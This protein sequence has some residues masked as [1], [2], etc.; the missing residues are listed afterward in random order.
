MTRDDTSPEFRF[1]E[2]D[3]DKVRALFEEAIR[4]DVS[5]HADFLRSSCPDDPQTLE[6]VQELLRL[7]AETVQTV[8]NDTDKP[9]SVMHEALVRSDRVGPFKILDMIGEGGFGEVYLAEQ[10]E[11]VKRLVALKVIKLG[12]DTRSVIARFEAERQALALMDDPGIARVYDAGATDE[13][14]PYF[15]MEYVKGLSITTYCDREKLDIKHRLELFVRVCNAVQHAHQKGVIHRDIKPSNILVTTDHQDQAQPKVIDFGIAKATTQQLTE[16][17]LHTQQGMIIGTPE[18]MSPEQSVMHGSDV[19][20]RSDVYSLG[21][22]LYELLTGILP[23]DS[24]MLRKKDQSGVIGIIR[25]GDIPKPSSRLGSLTTSVARKIAHVRA[26]SVSDLNSMLRRELEWIPLMAMRKDRAE[27]Y[28]SV[29]DMGNDIKRYLE[30]HPLQAGPE[31]TTYRLKKLI[32]RHRGP[33]VAAACI[34]VVLFAGL[35]ATSYFALRAM[36]GEKLAADSQQLAQ[37]QADRATSQAKEAVLQSERALTNQARAEQLRIEADQARDEVLSQV[38]VGNIHSASLAKMNMDART[39]AR[40]LEQ[41]RSSRG[42]PPREELPFEWRYL[43]SSANGAA[44]TLPLPPD[45]IASHVIY[46]PDGSRIAVPGYKAIRIQDSSTGDIID[47]LPQPSGAFGGIAFDPAGD[48][49]VAAD[50]NNDLVI[51]DLREKVEPVILSG[52]ENFVRE[53]DWT[54]GEFGIVSLAEDGIRFWNPDTLACTRLLEGQLPEEVEPTQLRCFAISPTG[55]HLIAAGESRIFAWNPA[56]GELL[57]YSAIRGRKMSKNWQDVAITPDGERFVIAG[58]ARNASHKNRNTIYVGDIKTGKML[59]MLFGHEGSVNGLAISADGKTLASASSDRTIRTWNLHSGTESG[60]LLGHTDSV[61]NVDFHPTE[62]HIATLSVDATLRTWNLADREDFFKLK[63][64]SNFVRTAVFS[65]D[66]GRLAT[67]GKDTTVNLWDTQSGEL[68]VKLVGHHR[69]ISRIVFSPDGRFL[70]S[71]GWDGLIIIWDA[72]TGKKIRRINAHINDMDERFENWSVTSIIYDMAISS[73]GKRLVTGGFD[74]TTRIWDIDSGTEILRMGDRKALTVT[75][76][77][78]DRRIAVG[79]D[80]GSTYIWNAMNGEL[81]ETFETSAKPILCVSFSPDGRLLAICGSDTTVDV[82][83]LEN[84]TQR[85]LLRGHTNWV[86][87]ATF[88]TDGSRLATAGRDGTIQIWDTET[89]EHLK[90]FTEHDTSIYQVSFNADGTQMASAGEDNVV[91]LW[92][93]RPRV[94]IERGRFMAYEQNQSLLPMVRSWIEDSNDNTDIILALLEREAGSRDP[95][96]MNA[97]RN[98]VIR[99]LGSMEQGEGFIGIGLE[100]LQERVKRM[101]T[102][103]KPDESE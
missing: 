69:D 54:H 65:P 101:I 98:V 45:N 9:S 95:E 10:L 40:N 73:D 99:E 8:E 86:N 85:V 34:L 14:R 79:H 90:T 55:K 28:A 93:T 78:D 81:L 2:S 22:L 3:A 92:E 56:D 13:G 84:G 11:P 52:H 59:E 60:I 89:F 19:D 38:Y 76:S 7:H 61:L 16:L 49:L 51:H 46:D 67:G 5:R 91:H 21:V 37:A 66:G 1:D 12:M 26:T 97:L 39:V 50:W 72:L 24:E 88:S 42:N 41:A 31:S 96:Q 87:S 44:M 57:W 75:F 82:R 102:N 103:E 64:H 30:G 36:E 70:A 83:E 68:L 25:E 58:Y 33:F 47:E 43:E 15:V 53:I 62:P 74:N 35:L 6:K 27:R 18:Y 48:R 77:P 32:R 4:M 100:Y 80:D 29:V 23:F 71:A 17:T 94:E 20:T 63:G